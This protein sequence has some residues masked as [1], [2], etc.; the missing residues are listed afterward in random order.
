MTSD[1]PTKYKQLPRHRTFP[2]TPELSFLPLLNQS[3]HPPTPQ[4]QPLSWFLSLET[5]FDCC[6]TLC[7]E[8]DSRYSLR[9]AS[10]TDKMFL[11]HP[12]VIICLSGPFFLSL[13]SSSVIQIDHSLFSYPP[14]NGHLSCSLCFGYSKKQCYGYYYMSLCIHMCFCIS[15]E[16]NY[17]SESRDMLSFIFLKTSRMFYNV[18]KSFYAPKNFLRFCKRK[19]TLVASQEGELEEGE[20]SSG[21]WWTERPLQPP[22]AGYRNFI[23]ASRIHKTSLLC[24][25]GS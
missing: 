13:E 18:A 19:I 11:R 5:G 3:P 24:L 10:F 9:Q 20:S 6:K 12:C 23:R 25:N 15:W 21:R 7:P 17:G 22:G 2:S 1:T 14:T 4:R 8:S 16:F